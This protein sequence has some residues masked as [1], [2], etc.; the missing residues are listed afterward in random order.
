MAPVPDRDR[1]VTFKGRFALWV[2]CRPSRS[3][4]IWRVS[5]WI[6]T[7]ILNRAERRF[8]RKLE[9]ILN[10]AERRLTRKLEAIANE[11]E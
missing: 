5:N 4:W 8:T 10:R 11:R 6:L 3:D 1:R 9:A 7:A 2:L